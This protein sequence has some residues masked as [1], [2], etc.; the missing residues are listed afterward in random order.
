MFLIYKLKH[1]FFERY[2][3]TLNKWPWE[4]NYDQWIQLLK[5]TIKLLF[6]N[7]FILLPLVLLPFY[8][9]DTC[10]MNTTYED[11]PTNAIEI[12]VQ[13][14]FFILCEDFGFYFSHRLLHVKWLYPYIHKIHHTY[15][16][17]VSI[18]AEYAHP[19][20]FIISNSLTTSL[21]P[22]I[23]GNRTHLFTYLLW[24]II[25]VGETADGHCGYE[26]SWSPYRLLFMSASEDFHNFHHLYFRD[27]YGS[28]FT[29]WD[30][31]S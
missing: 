10:P 5:K 12:M 13:I 19:V 30:R 24:I 11:L 9:K 20:E 23:L 26:F 15:R 2:K 27:N 29:F 4:E 7:H 22:F 21:G 18:S 6:L 8:L 16:Q 28:F 17:V 1:P 3:T 25:R 14:L 31:I